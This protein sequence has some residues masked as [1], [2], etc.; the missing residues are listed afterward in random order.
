[1]VTD[2]DLLHLKI[3]LPSSRNVFIMAGRTEKLSRQIQKDMGSIID[4]FAAEHFAGS[5]ITVTEAIVTP[6]LGLAKIYLS[7][8]SKQPGAT[9]IEALE[10]HN[11]E[12][13][14]ALAASLKNQVR[15]IPEIKFY[16][17]N[18]LEHAMRMDALIDQLNKPK[19]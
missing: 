6:D 9:I 3:Y 8:M 17:D 14:Q 18:T 12:L 2:P 15:R 19:K 10:L 4:R 11:K 5:L 16:L 13:R 1:M 7:V